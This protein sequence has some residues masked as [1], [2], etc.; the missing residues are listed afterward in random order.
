M[1]RIVSKLGIA[2]A[3]TLGM[4][5]TAAAQS[6]KTKTTT[7]KAAP[8]QV[9][10][11]T[12]NEAPGEVVTVHDTVRVFVH[13]TVTR[14]RRDTL[15]LTGPTVTRWD[16]VQ[17]V[18]VPGWLTPGNGLY[19]GLGAGS[20]Y[21]SGGI[22]GGQIPGYAFQMNLGVD[23]KGSPLGVRFTAGLAR[24]DEEQLYSAGRGRPEV[25]NMTGDLKLRLPFFGSSR[26]PRFS[27]YGVGGVAMVMFKDLYITQTPSA[28]VTKT[29]VLYKGSHSWQHGF[30]WDAGGGAALDIGHKRQLFLE[31][32]AINFAPSG[33]EN[34]HQVPVILGVNWY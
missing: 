1:T 3:L 18:Q 26:F 9:V 6:T 12:K 29:P 2:A 13:D 31:L 23:P 30:G 16:T 8:T 20:Y 22:G 34:P 4:L 15:T 32:R 10:P 24:P 5:S 11:V 14:F 17:V 19:F 28:T 7:K 33:Y 27:L 21:P 25:V